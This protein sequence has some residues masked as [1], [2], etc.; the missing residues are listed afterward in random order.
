MSKN[1]LDEALIAEA[2]RLGLERAMD[3]DPGGLARAWKAALGYMER[4][5]VPGI[6]YQ[7]PVHVF[8]RPIVGKDG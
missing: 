4:R 5:P 2:R 8:V 1:D 3:C 6:P 7:E